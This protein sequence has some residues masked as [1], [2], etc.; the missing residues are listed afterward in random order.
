MLEGV[1]C[2][3]DSSTLNP[4]MLQDFMADHSINP[5]LVLGSTVIDAN[6]QFDANSYKGRYHAKLEQ[7]DYIQC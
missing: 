7:V 6:A 3:G 2:I 5:T 1:P 4:A